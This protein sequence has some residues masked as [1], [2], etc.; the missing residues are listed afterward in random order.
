MLTSVLALM[1]S[2]PLGVAAATFLSELAPP[3]D[4]DGVTFLVELL[5]AVPSV[6][7]GLLAIF[8]LVP[9][10]RHGDWPRTEELARVFAVL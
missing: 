10:M 8:A 1:I 7:F 9:L 4:L 2:V 5:A 3:T 6:I